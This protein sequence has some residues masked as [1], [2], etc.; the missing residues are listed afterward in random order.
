MVLDKESETF[1]INIAA[2]KIL[3]IMIYPLQTTKIIDNNF[4]Q[5]VALK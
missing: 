3:E 2:L 4:M 5:D 1:I